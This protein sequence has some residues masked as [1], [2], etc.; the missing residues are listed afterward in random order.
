MPKTTYAGNWVTL[1]SGM[2]GI[3]VG[4]NCIFQ[5]N[6][7]GSKIN[8]DKD[9]IRKHTIRKDFFV[10][11]K[12]LWEERKSQLEEKGYDVSEYTDAIGYA[13]GEI[14]KLSSLINE[15]EVHYKSLEKERDEQKLYGV[16][17][18]TAGL[19]LIIEYLITNQS[20]KDKDVKINA[21]LNEITLSCKF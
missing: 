10:N 16:I 11:I 1:T 18:I 7:L 2:V 20:E 5:Y 6:S 3:L 12:P 19:V 13:Q 21:G 17:S 9:I 15:K 4:S 8:S 14:T